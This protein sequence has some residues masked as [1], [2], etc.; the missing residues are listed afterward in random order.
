M[1]KL[2]LPCLHPSAK[3][4][5][6]AFTNT[7]PGGVSRRVVNTVSTWVVFIQRILIY[8]VT[9]GTCHYITSISLNG[10]DNGERVASVERKEKELLRQAPSAARLYYLAT[11]GDLI[12]CVVIF[13]VRPICIVLT[14]CIHIY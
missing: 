9:R 14:R 4:V 1:R 11:P 6:P 5:G 7:P 3:R 12:P 13:F 8:L 2:F 10:V